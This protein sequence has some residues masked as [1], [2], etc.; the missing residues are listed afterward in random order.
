MPKGTTRRQ[1]RYN[2]LRLDPSIKHKRIAT[3]FLLDPNQK[4][5][6]QKPTKTYITS[7]TIQKLID[8]Q[9]IHAGGAVIIT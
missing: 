7:I 2:Y 6:N 9:S 8:K 4:Q 5:R 1:T 3:L